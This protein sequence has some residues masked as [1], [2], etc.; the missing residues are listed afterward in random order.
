[1]PITQ[2]PCIKIRELLYKMTKTK[3]EKKTK[4]IGIASGK[5]GV[6]KTTLAINLASLYAQKGKRVLIFDADIGLGNIHIALRNKLNGTLIDVLEGKKEIDEIL[7]ETNIGISIVSGGNGFD[8]ILAL[9]EGKTNS[10]IQSFAALQGQFDIMIVDISAGAD[11]SVLNFLSACHHQIVIGT[12]EPSSIADAYALIKLLKLK[13]GVE[14]IIFLPNRVK[15]QSEGNNME[16]DTDSSFHNSL[17][18]VDSDT[19]ALAYRGT[20]DDGFIS[21]FTISAADTTSTTSSS[22]TSS[23]GG[24]CGFDRDC[25]APRITNHGESETPDGFSI[26]D[27]IF[28]ENQERYNE[29]PTIQGTVGEPVTIKVRAWENMGTDKITLAIA[30]LAMHDEKPDWKDSTAN[31]EFSIQQDEFKVYDKNKIFSAVGAVTEKVEDPYEDLSLI[32]I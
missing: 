12:N 7:V 20:G 3:L 19:Y 5:G 32:H 21:T 23:S 4:V 13:I 30:Y 17:I 29:N 25:T 6:G 10:I 24:G 27:N 11:Q 2:V 15:T 28:E 14:E 9:D 31:I 8:E 22:T 26:N 18:Q 16:H 1:M